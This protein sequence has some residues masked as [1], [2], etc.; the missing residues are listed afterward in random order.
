M[1]E[2]NDKGSAAGVKLENTDLLEFLNTTLG[3]MEKDGTIEKLV[4]EAIDLSNS[5]K[6]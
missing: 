5:A 1:F 2:S 6:Q 4:T 3:E